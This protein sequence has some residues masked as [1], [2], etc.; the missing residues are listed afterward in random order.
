MLNDTRRTDRSPG[1]DIS[2]NSGNS[3]PA[4]LPAPNAQIPALLH[5]T[6]QPPAGERIQLVL[7]GGLSGTQ[8]DADAA[9]AA[10]NSYSAASSLSDRVALS[11]VPCGNPDGLALGSAPENGAGGN[12]SAAYPPPGDSYYDANPEAHYLWRW[13]SFQ[14][15]DLA[16]EIR[17]G[18]GATWQASAPCQ[19]LLSQFRSTLNVSELPSDSSLLA[20][21]ATGEP[22]LLPPVP[23][24]RLTCAAADL[25]GELAK[26]WTVLAQVPDHARSATRSALQARV[27]RSPLAVARILAGVYGHELDPVIYTQGVAVSGRLRLA[28]LDPDGTDPSADIEAIAAPYMSGAKP[29]FPAGGDGGANLAGL[30]WADELAAT[31]GNDSYADLLVQTADRYRAAHDNGVPSPSNPNYQVEDMFFTAAVLGRAF[32]LTGDDAYLNILTRFLLD[33][34][35]QQ[36][37]G[38]FWH[39][40]RTPFYWGRGNGFAALSYTEAL[41]YL[42]DSHPDR[43]A[44]L[45]IHRRH[46]H[47]LR[48]LSAPQRHVAPVD[49][50]ARLLPRDDRYLHGRLCALA[51][52]LRR[53]WLDAGHRDPLMRAWQGVAARIDDHGGLVDVCTGT[54]VQ[55]SRRDYLDRPAIFGPDERGGALSIWFVTEMEQL[56]TRELTRLSQVAPTTRPPTTD[57]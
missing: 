55:Q 44:V 16:L 10:L 18:A 40:R 34:N 42:P 31:T 29:W 20:A 41:T 3:T 28:Q 36:D 22:N 52:G 9:L 33:A 38:L 51:R 56:P 19:Q 25:A 26:L 30:V 48:E 53:G 24:L 14:G 4:A 1:Y 45:A 8:E 6:A 13:V 7:I 32:K 27:A 37:D 23:S 50:R 15:P 49:Q 46:L 57:H 35:V 54:G 39:D 11:A 5:G 47:A 2:P 17:V 43:A 12:P 21:L